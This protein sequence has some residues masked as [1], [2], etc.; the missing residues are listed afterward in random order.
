MRDKGLA[1]FLPTQ[2]LR[3]LVLEDDPWDAELVVA[4]LRKSAPTLKVE[5]LDSLELFR[6]R[7][8]EADFDIILADYN[9]NGWTAIDASETLRK[10]GKDIPLV[11]VTGALGDDAAVECV[12][13]GAADYVLKDRLERIPIAVDRAVRRKAYLD[14]VARQNQQIRHAKEEWELTFNTVARSYLDYG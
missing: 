6:Q 12:R 3:A 1:D 10:C 11:V 5:V 4:T 14:E 8:G 2:R 9:L 7:L 13:Q